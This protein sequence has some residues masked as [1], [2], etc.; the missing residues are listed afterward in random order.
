MEHI[1]SRVIVEVAGRSNCGKSEL[2]YRLALLAVFHMPVYLFTSSRKAACARLATLH[3]LFGQES[4]TSLYDNFYIEET[5]DFYKLCDSLHHLE[6]CLVGNGRSAEPKALVIID[7][8]HI[9]HMLTLEC[10]YQQ[11]MS[12]IELFSL[13]LKRIAIHSG[14][15]VVVVNSLDR[16]GEPLFA[17]RWSYCPDVHVLLEEDNSSNYQDSEMK[18]YTTITSRWHPKE[19]CSM[20][21]PR[22]Q[23][24]IN[25]E[26][27]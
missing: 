6:T 11:R 23:A 20:T 21:F 3:R 22:P 2:V 8:L 15:S 26:A 9:A 7:G 4:P 19:T 25:S 5:T 12:W 14:C 10:T 27:F 16:K 1:K 13:Q 18:I 17:P 24:E